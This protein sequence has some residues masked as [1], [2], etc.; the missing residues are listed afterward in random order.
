MQILKKLLQHSPVIGSFIKRNEMLKKQLDE[1]KTFYPPGHYYSPIHSNDALNDYVTPLTNEQPGAIDLNIAQQKKWLDAFIADSEKNIFPESQQQGFRYYFNNDYFAYNDGIICQ[2][3][4]HQLKPKRIIEVGSGFSSALMLDINDK[5]FDN[6]IDLKFIEPYP[7]RLN[8]LLKPG[9]K[10][11][12]F[13]KKIQEVDL[14][15]FEQLEENDILFIDST[16]VS[17]FN[18][19]V[20]KLFFEILPILKKGV[21][22]HIHDIFWSFDYPLQWLKEGR[23]WNEAYLLRAFL[24]FNDSFSIQFFNSFAEKYFE[25]QY[26]Q[27]LPQALKSKGGSIWIKKEK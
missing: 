22:I 13:E 12:L 14:K 17:K 10:I 3:L 21:Y 5:F 2:L 8:S 19:D 15:L 25:D 7:E 26:I 27:Q 20:N 16:H 1:Y 6:K 23:A 24:Q 18:S 4:I 9:E 11:E